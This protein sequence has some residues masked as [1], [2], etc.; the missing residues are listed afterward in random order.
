MIGATG[1]NVSSCAIRMSLVTPSITVGSWNWPS[2]PPPSDDGR[3]LLD[4]VGHVLLRP[5][6]HGRRAQRAHVGRVVQRVTD[7]Q[8]SRPLDQQRR[9]T[10]P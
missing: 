4:R 8:A 1:P 6:Q 7:L 3:A 9:R 5:L 10:G 2:L